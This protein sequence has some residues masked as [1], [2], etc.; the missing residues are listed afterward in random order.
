[1]DRR[2]FLSLGVAAAAAGGLA[3]W[4]F[5]PDQGLINPCQASLPVELANHEL[6][7]AAWDGIDP[8]KTWDSHAHL[9]GTGD[10]GG[11]IWINPDLESLLHPLQFAQRVFFLNAGCVHEAK[12]EADQSYLERMHNLVDGMRRGHKLL[13]YAFDA[14]Y[15]ESGRIDWERTA[16]H[17]SNDY[18]A[19][20]ARRYPDYFEWAASIHPYNPDCVSVLDAAVKAG[21]RAVKWLPAAQGMDPASPLCDRFYEALARHRLPLISH[22]G[23]ERAVHGANRQELGNPL[24]LR[25][26]LEHGV[27]VVVAHCA[28]MGEDQDLD[29]GDNGPPVESFQLFARMME[30]QRFEGLLFGDISAMTQQNRA[31]AALAR[32]IERTDWHHRLLNGSDYPLPGVMPLY[33]VDYMV[34]LG[35][36]PPSAAAPLTGIRRHNPLLFDFVLKRHLQSGGR[37]FAASV[38]ETRDFFLTRRAF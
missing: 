14:H 11:G 22:A 10:S 19:R 29:R 18:A 7:A 17:V 33:S 28:S 24:R 25:R 6:V 9:V 1:M 23:E 20:A 16:F 37:R 15:S 12:G 31:G 38:F 13:L 30:D 35:Y 4:R 36:I 32:V 8:A 27:R 34:S 5:W 26:A 3:A 2:R 21:A